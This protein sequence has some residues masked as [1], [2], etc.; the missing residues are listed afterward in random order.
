MSSKSYLGIDIGGGSLKAALVTR[1]GNI[2]NESRIPTVREWNNSEFINKLIDLILPLYSG[3]VSGIGIGSPGPIDS[4][5]GIILHSA[6][7]VNLQNVN[8]ISELRQRFTCPIVLNNDAN[9]ASLG[10]YHFGVGQGTENLIVLALGTGLGA[11]WVYRGELF[12]G[13]NGNGMELGHLT[14]IKEG[15][16]CGCGYKGCAESYFSARGLLARYE[17]LTGFSLESAESFFKMARQ[18]YKEAVRV[19]DFGTEVLAECI[20]NIVHTVNPEKIV[21]VGGLSA[22]FDLFEVKL[23]EQLKKNLF[24]VLYSRLK[25]E[26]GGKVAGTLGAASLVFQRD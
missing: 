20:R 25:I 23:K 4:E 21:F 13:F 10:E 15:A 1:D 2:L 18:G 9:C 14:I 5:N 11:G 19:L 16:L 22:S 8:L 7:L 6:N 24:P 17:E 26:V 3:E 12:N